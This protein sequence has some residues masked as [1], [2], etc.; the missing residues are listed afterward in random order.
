MQFKST[1]RVH[2]KLSISD[3]VS[4]QNQQLKTRMKI[5]QCIGAENNKYLKKMVPNI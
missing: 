2:T 3:A 4:I 5:I 1:G